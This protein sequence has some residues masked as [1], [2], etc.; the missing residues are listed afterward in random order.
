MIDVLTLQAAAA[1][2][3]SPADRLDENLSVARGNCLTAMP[4]PGFLIEEKHAEK[5]TDLLED[6]FSIRLDGRSV[7]DI[8]NNR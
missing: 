1:G 8:L 2:F 3:I 7:E 4:L 6:I 5:V